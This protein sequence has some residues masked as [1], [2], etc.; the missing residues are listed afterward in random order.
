MILVSREQ[1]FCRLQ[2]D[3]CNVFCC[4]SVTQ[5]CPTVCNLMDCSMP[6]F[7]VLHHLLELA[8]SHVHWVSDAFQPSRPLVSPSSPA[9]DLSQHQGVFKWVSSSHRWQECWSFSLSISPYNEYLGLISF[10][11]DWFD[12]LA[13]QGTLK[14]LLQHHSSK[15]STLQCSA[16]FMVQFT[17]LYIT[18]GKIIALTMW[19]FVGNLVCLLFNMLSRFVMSTLFHL[20]K[21]I[22]YYW[23]CSS[24][25]TLYPLIHL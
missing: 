10:R 14:S 1:H 23:R 11:I 2:N 13:V 17:H 8:Q 5:S 15:A 12:L 7:P 4:C 20:T 16:F 22:Q 18:T 6:G 19:T 21:L 25:C 9:F 24:C 3:Q